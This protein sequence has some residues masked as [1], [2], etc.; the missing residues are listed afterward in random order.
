[1]KQALC[2]VMQTYGKHKMA[3]TGALTVVATVRFSRRHLDT[4][5]INAGRREQW[6]CS[7]GVAWHGQEGRHAGAC[8]AQTSSLEWL[9]ED[10][11]QLREVGI[12]RQKC[13]SEGGRTLH[14]LFLSTFPSTTTRTSSPLFPLFPPWPSLPSPYQICHCLFSRPLQLIQ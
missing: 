12:S 8:M 1:M 3:S 11:D 9:E 2:R 10:L 4:L 14:H 13:V 6:C 5:I 7:N